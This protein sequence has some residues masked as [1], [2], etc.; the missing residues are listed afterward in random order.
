[1]NDTDGKK[2]KREQSEEDFPRGGSLG[3]APL[4]IRRIN[5][6]AEKDFLFEQNA[7]KK[8]KPAKA[9]PAA[10]SKRARVGTHEKTKSPSLKLDTLTNLTSAPP[11][12]ASLLKFKVRV[13]T[14]K[15]IAP[16][17]KMITNREMFSPSNKLYVSNIRAKLCIALDCRHVRS[18]SHP[19]DLT[20]RD[21]CEPSQQFKRFRHSRRCVRPSLRNSIQESTEGR[22]L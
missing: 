7:Q 16:N 18:R 20:I 14:F 22:G 3:L 10:T 9:T 12:R 1:M 6:K 2:R 4:E 17:S 13:P 8:K 21:D 5:Q 11:K 19:K 15:S